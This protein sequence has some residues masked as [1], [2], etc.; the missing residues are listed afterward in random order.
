MQPQ[1][2][3]RLFEQ[4][5][6]KA[7]GEYKFE[8]GSLTICDPAANLVQ[9]F[10]HLLGTSA[11]NGYFPKLTEVQCKKC[12]DDVIYTATPETLRKLLL[13][14]SYEISKWRIEGQD[15]ATHSGM[16]LY[17]G[18]LPCI[19]TFLRFGSRDEF[20]FIKTVLSDLGLCKLNEKHLRE[21][22]QRKLG[23]TKH[24]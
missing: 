7:V 2:E 15:V 9:H 11:Y 16:T 3:T 14:E 13:L 17:Y 12:R 8:I 6:D 5:L 22:K 21:I 1:R 19:S 18:Q 20:N 4:F 24:E 10:E 23:R